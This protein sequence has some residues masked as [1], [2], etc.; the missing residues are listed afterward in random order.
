VSDCQGH[1]VHEMVEKLENGDVLLLENVRFCPMEEKPKGDEGIAFAKEL[2]NLADYY[3]NDAFAVSHR[4]HT[5]V[6][7]VPELFKKQGKLAVS[8][9][10]LKKEIEYLSETVLH[11]KRPFMAIIGGA[12][13][14]T[15]IGVIEALLEKVDVLMIG[16]AMAY[17]FF[18]ALGKPIGKS[19]VEDEYIGVA[20]KVMEKGEKNR[21]ELMLPIDV[22]V[23]NEKTKKTEEVKEIGEDVE[24]VSVGS[25]TIEAWKKKLAKAKTIFWNGPVGIFE[26]P[27][28]AKAT[29]DLAKI[30]AETKAITIAGG[31]DVV[32]AVNRSGYADQFS[33]LSTGG[34][35]CLELIEYGSL[36][37]IEAL[38]DAYAD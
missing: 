4:K 22:L 32:A 25:K 9:L 28:F 23:F 20:K 7:Q 14:S 38:S 34:G 19:L 33:H 24:G 13:I 11:P 5:S 21:V 8:G 15:K 26:N 1:R 31:G 35:A 29:Y 37:G 30:I 10:L 18:K 17:T 27:E 36:P 16:G 3:V 6:Y 12:K 2:A